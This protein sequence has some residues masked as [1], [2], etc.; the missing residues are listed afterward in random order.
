MRRYLL[1]LGDKSTVGGVVIEGMERS[2]HLGRPLTYIDA[3]VLCPVCN[4]TG[5]IGWKGPHRSA[6]MMG[7]QQA[8]EGDVCICM[9]DPP[10]IMLA[11][12][13]TA[14]HE[15]AAHEMEGAG[16]GTGTAR[17]TPKNSV[18]T[19]YDELFELSD[20][21]GQ[22]LREVYYTV[23]LSNGELIHGVTDSQG[24]TMR[25]TTEGAHTTRIY[26]GHKAEV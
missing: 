15:F 19:T 8:L 23:R 20:G 21:K 26:L 18:P 24:R 6:T 5:V 25:H 13:D 14:W 12:Q 11:S 10:P 2:T 3:K 4:T 1:R 7:R 22:P 9:C 16:Y 17:E